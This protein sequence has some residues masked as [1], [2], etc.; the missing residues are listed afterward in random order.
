MDKTLQK[1]ANIL[2]LNVHNIDNIS[3]L[4]GKMGI[5]L[6]YYK[7]GRYS[8]NKFY[9]DMADDL[10]DEVYV[11][12]KNPQN[13]SFDQ[14]VIGIAWGIRY[15]IRNNFVE[16]NPKEILS[17]IESL[18]I[19]RYINDSQSQIP[20][21]IIGVYLHSMITDEV[22]IE[23]LKDLISVIIKKYEFNFILFLNNAKSI[24]YINSALFTL[25]ILE[26]H[27]EY[28]S[29]VYRIINKILLHLLY[30]N[31]I[32][33]IDIYDIKILFKLLSLYK[34]SSDEKDKVVEKLNFLFNNSEN[35]FPL[36]YLWQNFIYFPND[37]INIKEVDKYINDYFI[38]LPQENTLS[39]HKGLSS[40]GL[41]LLASCQRRDENSNI[42]Y[43]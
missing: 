24:T 40:I 37:N 32:E 25:S 1:I 22:D 30:N 5:L 41:N 20:I 38:F 10:L 36:N 18:L 43:I 23:K 34:F 27:L 11:K 4:E 15:L 39:I 21:S 26:N 29:Q 35:K 17:D 6:F 14:G 16:G 12:L 8:G 3:L 42:R 28:K 13:I 7:Y 9:S 19:S 33:N 2:T 31:Y